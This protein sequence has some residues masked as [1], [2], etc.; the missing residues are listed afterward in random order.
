MPQAAPG[1]SVTKTMT[2]QTPLVLATHSK[3]ARSF[4]VRTQSMSMRSPSMN[5]R[6]IVAEA[7]DAS[8]QPAVPATEAMNASFRRRWRR[9]MAAAGGEADADANQRM[10]SRPADCD[11]TRNRPTKPAILPAESTAGAV[12]A[13]STQV[14]LDDRRD[15][16]PVGHQARDV[17]D[18]RVFREVVARAR[19]QPL[20]ALDPERQG[21][22]KE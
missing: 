22:I 1:H 15:D 4:H 8:S 13:R 10:P 20:Q 18:R 21:E 12:P 17:V 14:L 5:E 11:A 19:V 7:S 3:R 6:A 16:E 2:R 9:R